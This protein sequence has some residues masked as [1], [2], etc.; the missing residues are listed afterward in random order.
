MHKGALM[1]S[2]LPNSLTCSLSFSYNFQNGTSNF[3]YIKQKRKG[4][5]ITFWLILLI[6]EAPL[7]IFAT[8]ESN[9]VSIFMDP[10]LF[11]IIDAIEIK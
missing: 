4:F 10:N 1:A 11:C 9:I 5:P 7:F 3:L 2:P 6:A 8:Y